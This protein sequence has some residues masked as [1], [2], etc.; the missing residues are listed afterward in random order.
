MGFFNRLSGNNSKD[1]NTELGNNISNDEFKEIEQP[2]EDEVNIE[3]AIT[4]DEELFNA[5][6]LELNSINT[7]M[8]NTKKTLMQEINEEINSFCSRNMEKKGYQDCIE[9]NEILNKEN[10]KKL[11][12]AEFR[13]IISN[14]TARINVLLRDL[15]KKIKIYEGAAML[16]SVSELN[17]TVTVYHEFSVEINIYSNDEKKMKEKIE[18][19]VMKLVLIA[20]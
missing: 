16:E 17:N 7:T 5:T 3:N 12:I 2:L 15:K 19:C 11:I 20:H 8:G 6:D 1:F 14:S 13:T 9:N 10:N 18:Y 4:P